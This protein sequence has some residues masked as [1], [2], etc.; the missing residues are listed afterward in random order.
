MYGYY[1]TCNNATD[2]DTR[3]AAPGRVLQ[4]LR[5]GDPRGEMRAVTQTSSDLV[6]SHMALGLADDNT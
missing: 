5:A 1:V 6:L 4:H 2:A 3:G